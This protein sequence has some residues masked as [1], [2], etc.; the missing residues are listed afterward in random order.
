MFR[1]KL[2]IAFITAAV[3]ALNMGAVAGESTE[4]F[5]DGRGFRAERIHEFKA[6][7]NGK[8]EL[9][10][11]VG[12]VMVESWSENKVEIVENIR[13]N[14][15]TREEAERVLE[16]Y[17]LRTETRGDV[18]IATGPSNYRGYV[19]FSYTVKLPEKFSAEVSTAGGD[20]NLRSLTGKFKIKTSGGD[21]EIT[22]C[23]GS[24]EAVTS[25]GDLELIKIKGTLF[26]STSGGDIVCHD[27]GDDLEL[28]TSGGELD[29]KRLKGSVFAKTSGGDVEVED[30]D[31]ICKV[32]TSGGEIYL[33]KIT[34]K[35]TIEA[36]TS[37]G[38][39]E[40]DDINGDLEVHT[41]GGDISAEDVKGSLE[42]TTS[43]GDIEAR[44]IT[45]N[46]DVSTSGGD[47][48]IFQ[49]GGFVEASTSG[50]DVAVEISQY[51]PKKDQHVTMKSSGGDL[52]ITL[53]ADFCGHVR[54]TIS[55]YAADLD[56]YEIYSDFP[57]EIRTDV[58]DRKKKK[59][60]KRWSLDGEIIGTG[61]INSGGDPII[62]ETTNGNI[63]IR[64]Q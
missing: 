59:P 1:T 12:D 18:I 55:V 57:L 50:G 41:S 5:K 32:E 7:M 25:G 21:I 4:L 38:D 20:L 2:F 13:I 24:I 53:P 34:S 47:L 30:I 27:C 31:G 19:R 16:D 22:E 35:R 39:I 23:E 44:N 60:Y 28:K 54:A 29:L 9:T 51:F 40:I 62:L 14:S 11:I 42:A 6:Q 26:A 3:L 37:G 45:E 10:R 48:E 36:K 33:K 56:E 43:G 63:Y 61:D 49:A 17:T 58:D 52:E 15:Y 64:K 46:L 8:L